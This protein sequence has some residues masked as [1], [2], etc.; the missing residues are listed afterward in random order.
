VRAGHLKSARFA[1][2]REALSYGW[3]VT[4]RSAHGKRDGMKSIKECV[5]RAELDMETL[6][7]HAGEASRFHAWKRGCDARCAARKRDSVSSSAP[8]P[9][10]RVRTPPQERGFPLVGLFCGATGT[11]R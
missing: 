2:W 4:A 6:V 7:W 9:F 1:R 8:Q 5:Y 10:C 11:K 3:C